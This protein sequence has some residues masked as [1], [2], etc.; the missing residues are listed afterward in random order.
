MKNK[1]NPVDSGSVVDRVIIQIKEAII[2]GRFMP[3]EK[4]P[5]EYALMDELHVS[6]NSL[7]EA[8][9][10]L[11]VMD[12]LEVRRGD[13]TYVNTEF[14]ADSTADFIQYSLLSLDSDVNEIAEVRVL[15]EEDVLILATRNH[16]EEDVALL[17]YRLE[18]MELYYNHKDVNKLAE[19]DYR[20]HLALIDCCRNR[21]MTRIAKGLYQ[22]LQ[23]SIEATTRSELQDNFIS[24]HREMLRCVIERDESAVRNAVATSL[25]PWRKYVKLH[26]KDDQTSTDL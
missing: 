21:F 26:Q 15:I 10:V 23:K 12:I 2:K 19:A 11:R 18:E 8:I 14:K 17:E 22:M 9:K 4:L 1:M 5:S 24:E 13:G 20:F 7:R 6:R 25:Y 16:T 3:G